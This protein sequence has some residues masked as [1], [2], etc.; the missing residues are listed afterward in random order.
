MLIVTPKDLINFASYLYTLEQSGNKKEDMKNV[1]IN[2]ISGIE[3]KT[4]VGNRLILRGVETKNDFRMHFSRKNAFGNIIDLDLS[5]ESFYKS[6]CMHRN[7]MIA[8]EQTTWK[9]RKMSIFS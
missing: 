5:I 3:L 7:L 9:R 2:H 6:V 8:S 4:K 1:V